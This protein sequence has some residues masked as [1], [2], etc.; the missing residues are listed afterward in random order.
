M[1]ADVA[2]VAEV[3]R[4]Y[5]NKPSAHLRELTEAVRLLTAGDDT[6]ASLAGQLAAG[7]ASAALQPL[8]V[9]RLTPHQAARV[10]SRRV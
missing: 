5:T 6:A 9:S 8:G 4:R 1:A 10:L 3:F 2:A 7:A